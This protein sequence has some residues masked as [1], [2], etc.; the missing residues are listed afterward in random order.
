MSLC[1]I[2]LHNHC[3]Y[4]G[5]DRA[6]ELL[7]EYDYN[8]RKGIEDDSGTTDDALKM[9]DYIK[10]DTN[11][12]VVQDTNAS[13]IF[14][15]RIDRQKILELLKLSKNSPKIS[16]SLPPQIHKTSISY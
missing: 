8:E 11:D 10:D 16:K 4:D 5:L 6:L 12:V 1:K 7:S 2:G 13:N 15:A 14:T 3:L 9:I